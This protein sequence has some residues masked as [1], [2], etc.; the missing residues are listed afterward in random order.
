MYLVQ[1]MVQLHCSLTS[2]IFRQS[3]PDA[4]SSLVALPL[5][6]IH[7][8]SNIEVPSSSIALQLLSLHNYSNIEAL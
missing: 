8:H 1:A 6:F 3:T 7:T 5:L 2:I 4:V